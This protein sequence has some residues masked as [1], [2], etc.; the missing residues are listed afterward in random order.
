M[1]IVLL[2]SILFC[3]IALPSLGNL[4]DA[5]L[6]E[7]RL[8]VKEEVSSETESFEKDIKEYIN[9][10]NESIEKRLSLVT[11]LIVGLM[12][13]IGIPLV[14]LTIMIGWRSIKDNAQER[15]NITEL[16]PEDVGKLLKELTSKEQRVIEGLLRTQDQKIEN[17]TQEI[18]NLKQ[19]RVA[20]S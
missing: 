8:I 7:I 12:A 2:C 3:A 15:K 18:E 17:L 19:Q 4:S 13:L 6:N 10:K 5:D 16:T 20:N 1:K 9:T 11:N 14:V